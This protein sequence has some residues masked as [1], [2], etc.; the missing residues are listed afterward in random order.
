MLK[1]M[2]QLLYVFEAWR[3]FGQNLLQIPCSASP[4]RTVDPI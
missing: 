3:N 1:L 2:P 4:D